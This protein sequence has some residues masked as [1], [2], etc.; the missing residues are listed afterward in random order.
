MTLPHIIKSRASRAH[1]QL[2]SED[3]VGFSAA[4]RPRRPSSPHAREA[5]FEALWRG[6]YYAFGVDAAV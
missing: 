2:E 5:A 4:A 6:R 3:A 1:L